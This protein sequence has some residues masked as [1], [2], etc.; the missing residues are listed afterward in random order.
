MHQA[1]LPSD[2]TNMKRPILAFTLCTLLATT[3]SFLRAQDAL[4]IAEAVP[5]GTQPPVT[6]TDAT[7]KLPNA[8]ALEAK[9][10]PITI[11]VELLSGMRIVGV[12]TDNMQL[13]MQTSFGTASIPTGEIAAVRLASKEDTTTTIVLLNGDSITGATDIK[14][15]TVETEWG[16]AKVNGT[17]IQSIYFVPEVKWT[18]SNTINGPR[19]S[20]VDAKAQPGP[21]TTGAPGVQ[22]TLGSGT[23]PGQPGT[24]NRP[25][26][27]N[28]IAPILNAPRSN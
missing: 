27:P 25:V 20:L 24:L 13:S 14:M 10:R 28:A 21:Q 15:V 9:A 12:L 6:P 8:E 2:K 4:P 1:Y 11:T 26:A 18:K 22:P 23:I 3:N 17:A 5:T 19:W 16:S 7:P